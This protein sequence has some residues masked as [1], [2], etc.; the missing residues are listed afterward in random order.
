[1]YFIKSFLPRFASSS[2]EQSVYFYVS[3]HKLELNALGLVENNSSSAYH[4][5][6]LPFVMRSGPAIG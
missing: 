5:S 6:E 3:E 2:T 1:M 4:G